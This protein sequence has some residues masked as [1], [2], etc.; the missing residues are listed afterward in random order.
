MGTEQLRN[1]F[2]TSKHER[3]NIILQTKENAYMKNLIFL[4]KSRHLSQKEL[5]CFLHIS[6]QSICKYENG[7]SEANETLLI[8]TANFFGT[9]VDYLL[10][11]CDSPSKAGLCNASE[12][13]GSSTNPNEISHLNL[14]RNASREQQM[15]VDTLLKGCERLS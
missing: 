10:G 1:F 7:L 12:I 6:Q 15:A 14:Y 11:L 9:S 13:T 4:R 8:K 3:L 5:S 2:I